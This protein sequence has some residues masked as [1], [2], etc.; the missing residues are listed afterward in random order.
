MKTVFVVTTFWRDSRKRGVQPGASHHPKD[1]PSALALGKELARRA[2][3]V[4]VVKVTG[5][6]SVDYW[7][8][9]IVLARYGDVPAEAA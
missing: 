2:G 3:G 7:E 8:D 4:V 5:E 9:P 6:P 1:E